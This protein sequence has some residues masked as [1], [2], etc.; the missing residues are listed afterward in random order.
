MQSLRRCSV[1]VSMNEITEAT[2]STAKN[3]EEQNL[4]TQNIQNAIEDTGLRSKDMVDVAIES[5]ESIRVN[6]QLMEE[7]QEQSLIIAKTNGD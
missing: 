2:A 3:I 4:M 1:A 5:N 6:L 7:L